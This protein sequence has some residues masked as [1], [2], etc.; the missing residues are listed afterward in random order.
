MAVLLLDV[1]VLLHEVDVVVC[2]LVIAGERL[3]EEPWQLGQ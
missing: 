2:S 3:E 1:K